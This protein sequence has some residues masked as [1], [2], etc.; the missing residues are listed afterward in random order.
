MGF[1][2]SEVYRIAPTIAALWLLSAGPAAAFTSFDLTGSG[3]YQGSYGFSADGIGLSVSA[4][5]FSG[6]GSVGSDV[7]VHQ[8]STGLGVYSHWGDSS[9][10]DGSLRNDLLVFQFDQDV[11]LLA[12][13]FTYGDGNDDFTF[14]F[15]GGG[16]GDLDLT[17]FADVPTGS[18]SMTY[19]FEQSWIGEL[20]GIGALDTFDN[21]RVSG[22]DV[23]GDISG[24]SSVPLPL[25]AFLLLGG[26]GL[27]VAARHAQ[28]KLT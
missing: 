11:Q 20:F 9:Q 19:V 26:C 27:F 18:T 1:I 6:S 13:S 4:S 8:N 22:L 16:D 17:G 7:L 3:G 21:F 25:P 10:V 14:F 24:V 5:T 15:D 23:E 2:V 28:K 12:A